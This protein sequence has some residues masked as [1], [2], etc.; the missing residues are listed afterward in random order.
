MSHG[1]PQRPPFLT[2]LVE[3]PTV[4]RK[5]SGYITPVILGSLKQG[6]IKRTMYSMPHQWC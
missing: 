5:Q 6:G 2:G 3:G 4:G 1:P